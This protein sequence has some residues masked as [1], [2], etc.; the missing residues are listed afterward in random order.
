MPQPRNVALELIDPPKEPMREDTLYQGMGELIEDIAQNGLINAI[1]IRDTQDGRYYIIA[2]HRRYIAH[3][4][5][6][7]FDIRCDVYAPGEGDDD[8][9]RGSEN[10]H[11]TD[12][13]PIEE[14]RFY[15]QQVA[16]HGISAS[17]VARRY[18]RS[19][20]H[21]QQSLSLLAGDERVLEAL[22]AGEINKGQALE[23]NKIRDELGLLTALHYAKNQGM[24]VAALRGFREQRERVGAD[25]GA[26]N[27]MET[28][29]QAQE[30][31]A[32]NQLLCSFSKNW[33]DY[34]QIQMYQICQNCM[35]EIGKAS[36]MYNYWEKLFKAGYECE[37]EVCCSLPKP[38]PDPAPEEGPQ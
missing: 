4:E 21:V 35:S 28:I 15:A 31:M 6:G 3:K 19:V 14:A 37:C 13:N 1:S 11:R 8:Q 36:R 18:K 25:V 38:E 34:G 32:R 27:V 22:R 7:R 24:T 9:I 26:Q 29:R 16:K 30:P 12:V 17:E 33:W 10:F 2:G 5:M 23:L 20:G